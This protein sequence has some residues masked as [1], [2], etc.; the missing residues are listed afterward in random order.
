MRYIQDLDPIMVKTLEEGFR[1]GPSSRFRIRCQAILLSFQG[2]KI[3]DLASLYKVKRDTIS[4]WFNRWERGGIAAL[5]D[6]PKSGRPPKLDTDNQAHV[7]R[8]KALVAQES[9]QLDLVRE[10]LQSEFSLEFSRKTLKRFLKSLVT[11]GSV[12]E[13]QFRPTETSKITKTDAKDSNN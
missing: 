5:L 1:Y 12:L 8:V 4:E 7:D 10:Q 11:D 6:A 9:Q 13:Y 2:Q 3:Q